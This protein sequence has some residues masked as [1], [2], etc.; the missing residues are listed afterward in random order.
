MFPMLQLWARRPIQLLLSFCILWLGA[1]SSLAAF[2]SIASKTKGM[3]AMPGFVDLYWDEEKGD[4]YMAIAELDKEFI[5][6]VSLASGLGSNPVGLDRGQLGHTFVLEARKVGPKIY[7]WEKNYRFRADSDNPA[8]RK[9]VQEAFAQSVQWAFPIVARSGDKYLLKANDYFLRDTHQ[10]ISRLKRAKQGKFTL[11]K[12]RSSFH[13]ER[14]KAFPN[15]TE[16]EV[17]LTYASEKPGKLVRHVA[18]NASSVSLRQHHT[19]IAA[20][21]GYT[22]RYADPRIGSLGLTYQDYGSAIEQDLFVRLAGRHRLEKKFPEQARSEVKEPIVYYVDGGTPEPIRSALIEGAL[23]WNDAF[24][25]AGFMNAFQVKV[26]PENADPQDSRYNMIHWTHRRTRGYSYGS[27]IMDPRTGEIIKGNVNLGSLRLRQDYLHARKALEG[28][29]MD[30]HSMCQ[31][32]DSP[33]FDYL[34]KVANGSDKA[35]VEMAL[36]R[37]R[38]LSAH[39]VGHTIGLPHNFMAS[40]YGRES[41]MDYPAPMIDIKDGKLDV[42]NAYLQRIGEYDKLSV[43]W[44]YGEFDQDKEQTELAA[45]IKESIDRGLIYIN[46][47]N[48]KFTRAAHPKTSVWDNGSNLVDQLEHEYKVRRIALDNFGEHLL[49]PDEPYS[50]LRYI[51]LPSY[52]HHRFQL[53]A[54]A[55]TLGGADYRYASRGDGQ[56]TINIVPAEEQLR[57]LDLILHSLSPEFLRLPAAALELITPA[58][59]RFN[60]GETLAGRANLIFDTDAAIEA[61][62]ALSIEQILRPERLQRLENFSVRGDYPSVEQVLDRLLKATWDVAPAK[63]PQDRQI[64]KVVQQ[65]LAQKMADT[66]AHKNTSHSVRAE[67]NHKLSSLAKRLKS[68][69]KASAHELQ[70]ARNI[71]HWLKKQE[72]QLKSIDLPAGDPI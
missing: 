28:Y 47:I 20:P 33:S 7:F 11:D 61:S 12:K 9:A 21:E 66:A 30:Q 31:L 14:T 69:R 4:L 59:G 53:N 43:R 34:A 49:R 15:N 19:F 51:L 55:Q 40:S 23:W 58:E 46:H 56:Q 26:L 10:V 35:A 50:N 63:D 29:P 60:Q 62:A 24:E 5:Y 65:V 22:P 48:N 17:N 64:Q 70:V 16:V 8:E 38:Q 1:N 68:K 39:E 72:S 36:A 32:A 2:P 3:Q 67:L 57:A 71:D 37:V 13:L 45:I 27:F 41:V 52:M 44:L 25:A 42:S 18:A 54:A 6:Q